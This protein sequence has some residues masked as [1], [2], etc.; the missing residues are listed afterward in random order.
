LRPVPGQRRSATKSQVWRNRGF[1]GGQLWTS[2]PGRITLAGMTQKDDYEL[3][4]ETMSERR[5]YFTPAW[6]ADLLAGRLSLGDTFWIGNFGTALVFV[7]AQVLLIVLAGLLLP[8]PWGMRLASIGAW[9]LAAFHLALLRAVLKTALP[10]HDTGGWRWAGVAIT[11]LI[12]AGS[13]ST[14]IWLLTA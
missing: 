12:A 8:A 4:T 5:R 13:I 10:R 9:A 6:F 2:Q 7:P 3:L 1:T 11:A 14:A